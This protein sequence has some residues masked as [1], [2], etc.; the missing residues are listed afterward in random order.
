MRS[1]SLS[2]EEEI[3]LNALAM[4]EEKRFKLQRA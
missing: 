1:K 4:E 2:I 3:R